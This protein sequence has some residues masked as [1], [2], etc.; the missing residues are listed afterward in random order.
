MITGASVSIGFQ[1]RP[2]TGAHQR[3]NLD[4]GQLFDADQQFG[5]V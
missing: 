2:T 4:G 5:A 3:H 1:K